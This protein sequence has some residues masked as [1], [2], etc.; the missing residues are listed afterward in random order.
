MEAKKDSFRRI[1]ISESSHDSIPK[2]ENFHYRKNPFFKSTAIKSL[3]PSKSP[4]Q[5]K[6]SQAD[7]A[8]ERKSLLVNCVHK[9]VFEKWQFVKFPK[10]IAIEPETPINFLLE[11]NKRKE[12]ENINMENSSLQ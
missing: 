7:V 12:F 9:P 1:T 8:E 4:M 3:S 6:E 10:L 5:N 11:E 2:I